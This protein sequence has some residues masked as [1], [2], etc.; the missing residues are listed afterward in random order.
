MDPKYISIITEWPVP[1]SIHN[2]QVFLDLANYYQ[3]FIEG[4]SH[5]V[6]PLTNLLWKDH[7]FKWSLEAQPAFDVIKVTYI[8]APV[9]CH[10]NPELSIQL[11][12]DSSSF[13]LSSILSQLHDNR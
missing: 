11:H 4:Y 1:E 6:L 2:V 7:P 5:I 10:F 8:S 9:L 12:T 3:C 13:I